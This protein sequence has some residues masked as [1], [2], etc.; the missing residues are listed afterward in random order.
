MFLLVTWQKR[1]LPC[2]LLTGWVC[3]ELGRAPE[4]YEVSPKSSKQENPLFTYDPRPPALITSW[5][6]RLPSAAVLRLYTYF[7]KTRRQSFDLRL[8]C[9][10][11]GRQLGDGDFLFL[12]SAVF[13][14]DF[15]M[16][17]EKLV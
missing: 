10:Q 5:R 12:D 8:L 11:L 17:F 14:V 4:R 16:L 15:L 13:S 1:T 2:L 3:G 6:L 7:L 9:G